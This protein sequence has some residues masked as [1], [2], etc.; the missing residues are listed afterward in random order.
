M[1]KRQELRERRAR[2]KKTQ[3]ILL[4]SGG[5]IVVA[6]IAL[7]F[8]TT[9]MQP[10]G[11]IDS[12]KPVTRSQVNFNTMGDPNAPV[13]IVEYSNFLCGHC[14]AFALETEPLLIRDYIETGKV[15]FEYRSI[16]G[17]DTEA[18]R[19]AEAAYCAGDQ[20]KFW[21]MKDILFTNLKYLDFSDHRLF[22][23]AEQIGL[24]SAQFK[25]CFNSRKYAARVQED[26]TN[27]QNDG[28][29]GTPTFLLSN[30][31]VVYGNVPYSEF[32]AKIDAALAAAGK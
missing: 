25:D 29:E 15:F 14:A 28:V 16:G 6:A 10:I 2:Q 9:A 19:T 18:G 8:I 21:E 26:A 20:G 11:E 32:Q 23:F 1:S 30:G 7:F 24:D 27:A 17:G 4:I 13:K 31:D 22:A 12:P 3:R 5:L